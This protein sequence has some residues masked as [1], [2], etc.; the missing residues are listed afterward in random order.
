[1]VHCLRRLHVPDSEALHMIGPAGV[2]IGRA[3]PADIIVFEPGVSRAHC[4]VE[5]AA[6][7]LRVLDLNS[8]NGTY[9]DDKRISSAEILP[10]G[11]VLRVGNISFEHELRSRAE[12][13]Q[14]GDM[15]GYELGT[16]REPRIARSS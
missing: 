13:Q 9:I 7:K 3:A 11:S 8:T 1:M 12:L 10:V 4:V 14:Q 6:D 2:K 15:P 16:P 5:F